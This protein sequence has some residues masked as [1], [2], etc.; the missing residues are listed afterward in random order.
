MPLFNT[1]AGQTVAMDASTMIELGKEPRELVRAGCVDRVRGE[2]SR[3][4]LP[5]GFAAAQ[6]NGGLGA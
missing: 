2:S 6:R 4:D 3:T 5:G 1:G